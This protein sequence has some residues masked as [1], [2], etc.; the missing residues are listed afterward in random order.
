[1]TGSILVDTGPLVAF[2]NKRERLHDWAVGQLE[3]VS[4]PVWTCEAV[5]TEAYYLLGR[6]AGGSRALVALVRRG[7]V[8][9]IFRLDDEVD[10]VTRLLDRYASVPMSLADAC[11]VRLAELYERSSIMTLDSDF[12]IYRK[13]SRGVIPTIMPG[14]GS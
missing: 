10:A 6:I 11:L 7:L 4:P 9:P 13:H 5:L 14:P 1:M 12:T 3:S 2:I 8:R